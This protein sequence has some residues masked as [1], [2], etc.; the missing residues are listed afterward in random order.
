MGAAGR[1]WRSIGHKAI[2]PLLFLE[3]WRDIALPPWSGPGGEGATRGRDRF[4]PGSE[5]REAR[6]ARD[7]MIVGRGGFVPWWQI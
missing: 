6:E 3:W 5:A 1:G 7:A 4:D 2:E